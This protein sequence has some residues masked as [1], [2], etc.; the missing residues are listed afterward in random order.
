MKNQLGQRTHLVTPSVMMLLILT[1]VTT[2]SVKAFADPVSS[3]NTTTYTTSTATIYDTSYSAVTQQMDTYSTQLI[4]IMQGSTTALYDQT[5]TVAFSDP[6]VQAA[7][8]TAQGDLTGSGATSIIGP[9]LQSD[10]TSLVSSVSQTGSPVVTSTNVSD[11]TSLYVGPQTIMIGDNQLT[12]FSIPAGGIDFDT[13]ITSTIYQTI[14][15]TTTNTYLI[16][17]DYEL[18]G[19]PAATPAPVPEPATLLLLGSGLIGVIGF[20]KKFK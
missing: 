9:T 16:T 4:A 19:I 10:S 8:L 20:R 14:T 6:V 17:D 12:S 5:F 3:T 18:V 13:L 1:I 15:T 11:V 7:I 2:L